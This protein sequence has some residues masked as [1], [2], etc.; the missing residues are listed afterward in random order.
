MNTSNTSTPT[1]AQ[2]RI[3]FWIIVS[4]LIAILFSDVAT[5]YDALT[6]Q[7]WQQY[8]LLAMVLGLTV[9]S[10]I[11]L[12]LIRQNRVTLAMGLMIASILVVIPVSVLLSAGLGIV[13]GIAGIIIVSALA[14]LT[15]PRRLVGWAVTAKSVNPING[16]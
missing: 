8:L 5:A 10:C 11:D 3:A 12:W 1:A 6:T 15:L 13:L 14:G 4:L 2:K 16:L 9:I 7:A